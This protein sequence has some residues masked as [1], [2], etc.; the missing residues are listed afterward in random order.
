MPISTNGLGIS[1]G[2]TEVSINYR[3]IYYALLF[4]CKPA[5]INHCEFKDNDFDDNQQA[6]IAI[7][8]P[9]STS[10]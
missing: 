5:R 10:Y 9:D 4:N 6:K 2:F 3:P 8:P 7:C 1:L